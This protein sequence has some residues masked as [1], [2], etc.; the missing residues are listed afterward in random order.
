MR[1]RLQTA[2]DLLRRYSS[3]FGEAWRCR[4]SLAPEPLLPHEAQFLPAALALQETPVSPAPRV[5]Q[6]LIVC[7]SAVALAWAVVGRL[8]VVAVAHGKVVP[9]GRVKLVQPAETAT[10]TAI[11]VRDGE[12]VAA[13]DVLVELDATTALAD[14]ARVNQEL[15]AAALDAARASATLDAIDRP[16]RP[17]TLGVTTAQV[18]PERLAAERR[19]LEGQLHEYRTKL[20]RLEAEVQRRRAEERATGQIVA[21]LQQAAPIARQRADDFRGLMSSN[22]VSKHAYLEREQQRIELDG[23]LAAQRA[24]LSEIGVAVTEGL[25]QKEAVTAEFRRSV[26]EALDEAERKREA[27]SQEKIKADQRSKLTRLVAPV[28]GTVQQLAVHTVGGVVTPAQPL[29]VVVPA[30]TSLEI[31]AF[32]GNKDIG[33]VSPGQEVVIKVETFPFT[34]YGTLAGKIVSVSEDAIADEKRGLVFASRVEL[35]EGAVR[36]EDRAI[37]LSP[38]MAVSAEIKTGSR[39]VIDYFL[40]PLL[41]AGS[42]SLRER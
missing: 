17:L 42:E 9:S 13:G 26:L 15:A 19:L 27:L 39:R 16:D 7:F 21:K 41:Q 5:A 32:V 10:V 25:R 36:V 20:A 18:P 31:E 14:R 40:S 11:H 24:K 23:D 2:L 12:R 29:M 3:A 8:D 28:D 35:E 38:G 6:G 22:F 33:F 30:D 4:R 1:A 37:R 34:R